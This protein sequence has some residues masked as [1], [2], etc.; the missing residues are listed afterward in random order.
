MNT[1]LFEL[2]LLVIVALT[3]SAC[4][5]DLDPTGTY[6]LVAADGKELPAVVSHGDMEIQ[7][8]SGLFTINADGTCKSHTDFGPPSGDQH[9]TRDVNA[10]YTQADSTLNM[11]WEGAGQTTGTLDGDT[12]TM[13]NEGMLFTYQKVLDEQ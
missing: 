6:E 8:H 13:N 12:F 4:Q 7:V 10:T 5:T 1:R 11:R 3:S 9:V 2:C